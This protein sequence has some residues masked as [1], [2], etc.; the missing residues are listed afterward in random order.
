MKR[1]EIIH[2]HIDPRMIWVLHKWDYDF[3]RIWSA[4]SKPLLWWKSPL[5]W[6]DLFQIDLHP[7]EIVQSLNLMSIMKDVRTSKSISRYNE[8]WILY[9]DLHLSLNCSGLKRICLQNNVW[10]LY[11]ISELHLIAILFI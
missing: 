9:L 1:C 5:E 8:G 4:L 6:L 10:I 2:F 11:I 7:I 3:N